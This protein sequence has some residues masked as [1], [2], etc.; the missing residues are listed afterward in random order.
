M[1][2]QAAAE[3]AGEARSAVSV[4]V[5]TRTVIERP[6]DVVAPFASDPTNAPAWYE[7]IARVDWKTAPPARVGSIVAFE[8]R[9]LGRTLRYDYEIV[10][11]E[12][13]ER[14]VMRTSQGPFPMQTT[15][16]W[17]P[18]GPAQTEMTLRNNGE[19]AGFS[20]LVTPLMASAMRRAN[21]KDL[22]R[23]KALLE[24]T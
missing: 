11:F 23:L 20:R 4:D 7:N 9:F 10:E 21:R 12:A 14:L 18:S 2:S 13:G 1:A 8:A 17:R 3:D 22:A 6:V 24:S 19:P 5:E 15:Y 16:T